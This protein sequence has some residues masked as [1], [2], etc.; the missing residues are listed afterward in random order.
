MSA[1]ATATT[2]VPDYRHA[3][4]DLKTAADHAAM[5][6]KWAETYG[7]D[8]MGDSTL[9]VGPAKTVQA[10][11]AA[12]GKID[13]E[14]LDAGCGT[15]LGGVALAKAGAK[16]IDGMDI[17]PGMLRLAKDTGCYRDLKIV[18][19]LKAIDYPTDKYDVVTCIG[20]FT[21]GHVGPNPGIEELVRV[22]KKGGVLAATIYCGIWTSEGFDVEVERLRKVGMVDVLGTDLVDYRR[23]EGDEGRARMLV[24]RK[25]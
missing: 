2:T 18:D 22:L 8:V 13:G 10:V 7:D 20:T 6:D 12:N 14:I 24:L 17:S 16:A 21:T 9:Y 3:T 1:T 25:R 11:Q 5:Y 19:M 15:G 4:Y 23:A